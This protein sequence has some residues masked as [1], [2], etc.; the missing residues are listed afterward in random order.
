MRRRLIF[1]LL[2]GCLT[3][4]GPAQAEVSSTMENW[5]RI[6]SRYCT[7]WVHPAVG[8]KQV[9]KKI[10]TWRVRPKVKAVPKGDS[11]SDELAGKCDT[12]FRR[13]QEILDMYPAG[14][15]VTIKILKERSEIK[16]AHSAHYGFGTKAIAF[17]AYEENTIYAEADDLSESVLVHEMAHCIIDHYFRMRPPRKIEEMLA[18]HVDAQLRA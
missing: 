4:W 6:D 12:L 5:K 15:Q 18:T 9:N 3:L 7:I 16:G 13:A 2:L 1:W 10:S 14:I 11:V 8:V 17:Y